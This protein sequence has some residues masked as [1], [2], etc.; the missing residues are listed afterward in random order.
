[1]TGEFE[2]IAAIRERLARAGAPEGSPALVV[3]SGDDAA[4]TVRNGAAVTS[5]D[6]LVE[7]V[8]FEI[9]PFEPRQ[10]GVKALAV[11]LSDLAAM[12]AGPGEA[13]VQLGV[14]DAR[15]EAELLELADG[16]AAVAA[17]HGVAI[18]G[19]DVTRAPALLVAVTVVGVADS[20]ES[21]V[22]RA[23]ARPGEVVAVTGELG[24]AAAGLLLLQRP[25]LAEGI[26]P[27]L[28]ADL[29]ARQLEP[30]PRLAA[31]RARSGSGASALIDLS[32]GL[33]ADAGHLAAAGEVAIAI[34]LERLPIQ[35][36]VEQ[37]AR[38]AALDPLDLAAAG[39]EDYEL[40]ATIAPERVSEARERLSAT[41]IELSI[42]GAVATGAGVELSDRRGGAARTPAGFD[43]LRPRR[44]PNERA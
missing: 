23:G 41:G 30:R 15:T 20:A 38:A 7:G 16:L 21:V 43:Q 22:T 44:A 19:G 35:A 39:G 42:I 5:V 12:G 8:H 4:I 9:P 32:D 27:S 1:L 3:G 14:P 40:L 29:R 2:L 18:A 11:A 33:G 26:D 28:A 31:G 24:G 25:E 36:G 10:V 13:Y 37:V 17:E 34:E 6:A